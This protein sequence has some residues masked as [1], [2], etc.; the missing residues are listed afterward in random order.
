MIGYGTVSRFL[1]TANQTRTGGSAAEIGDVPLISI[2]KL[3]SR[4]ADKRRERGLTQNQIADRMG[5]TPQAV[6]KWERGL[7][8]P[9]IAFLDDLADLLGMSIDALLRGGAVGS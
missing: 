3:G 1:L 8:C 9:D 5:V 6:S 7:A 2:E 4:I